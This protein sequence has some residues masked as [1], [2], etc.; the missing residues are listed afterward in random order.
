[1]DIA[2]QTDVGRHKR[3][4]E[5]C[6]GV[7]REDT[8]GLQLFQEGALLCVADGLGGHVGGEIASKL[9]VSLLKDCLKQPRPAGLD[10]PEAQN[11]AILEIIRAAIKKANDNIFRTNKDF[12]KEGKPMGTTLLV[13]LVDSRKAYV[14]NVG[15]SRCYHIRNNEVIATTEDHSWVD[16]QVK[17]GLMSRAEAESDYRRNFLT[18]SIGTHPEVPV[19]TYVWHVVQGDRLLLC[20]DGLVNMVK[21]T[22]IR[23]IFGK[24]AHSA[25]Y[26]HRLVTL[27]LDN[28][29][30]DNVTVVVAQIS[31]SLWH[32]FTLA[33]K[34]VRKRHGLKILLAVVALL[35]FAAGVAAGYFYRGVSG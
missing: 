7:F 31:P 29:G 4:N 2:A 8:P 20:T 9:A 30:R 6:Y 3:N 1:M 14:A 25:E 27:A 33:V 21:D 28:G 35:S 23:D 22:D 16:E 12:V 10:D 32:W 17:L 5:D 13:A 34:S 19:D 11:Q 26:A 15:D 18:R 24:R